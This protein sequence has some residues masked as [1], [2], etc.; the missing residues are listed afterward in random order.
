MA[1]P[2]ALFAMIASMALAGAAVMASVD[3]QRGTKHDSGSKSAIAAADAGVSV[4]T[5]R[6]SRYANKLTPAEP[7]LEESGGTL[8]TSAA[9]ASGWCP[10]ITGTVGNA[11]YAYQVSRADLPCGTYDLCIV[12]TGILAGVSRRIEMTFNESGLQGGGGDQTTDGE[13]ASSG[14]GSFEGLVGQDGIEVTGSANL[15]VGV[16]T[17]GEILGHNHGSLVCGDMRVGVGKKKPEVPQCS[18]YKV[19]YGNSDLP[20]VSSFM[21]SNIATVNSNAKITT[22]SNQKLPVGCQTDGYTGSWTQK[23]PFNPGTRAISLEGNNALTVTGGDY[24]I[25]TLKLKGNSELI[26]GAGAKVRFFFDTPEKCNL[27]SGSTQIDLGGS[28]R[29][30]AT[31]YQPDFKHFDMPGFYLL[32]STSRETKVNLGGNNATNEVVIYGPNTNIELSG[33][34]T[35]KGLIAGKWITVTGSATVEEDAGYELPPELQP[36]SKEVVEEDENG[37]PGDRF[38]TA[39]SYVEC[40]GVPTALEEPNASC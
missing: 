22:C 8:V 25:C 38:Y 1:L 18:N 13:Q 17:N 21:P 6:L 35:Y 39:Q 28:N 16:G 33:S 7:C 29:I 24:W 40:I 26:M 10:K 15:E 9:P 5:M 23:P 32:G 14:G 34:A 31:G 20:P 4:A 27:P 11:T 3:V 12:S 2:V 36:P 30:T 37:T 19:T